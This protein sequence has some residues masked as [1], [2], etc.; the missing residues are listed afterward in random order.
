MQG[1]A[2]GSPEG[3]HQAACKA[4]RWPTAMCGTSRN[5]DCASAAPDTTIFMS[6][7]TVDAPGVEGAYI[8]CEW[9]SV[10]QL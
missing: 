10:R 1:G 7:V 5:L 6:L 3:G 8:V 9:S 4:D 2:Q